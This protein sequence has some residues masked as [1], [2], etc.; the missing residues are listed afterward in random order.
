[1]KKFGITVLIFGLALIFSIS[2]GAWAAY[3]PFDAQPK[4]SC[5]L[6]IIP[7]SHFN[8]QYTASASDYKVGHIHDPQV[9][10]FTVFGP[11]LSYIEVYL[12][13]IDDAGDS[14]K[15]AEAFEIQERNSTGGWQD[16][17]NTWELLTL[18]KISGVH[19]DTDWIE[20]WWELDELGAANAGRNLRYNIQFRVVAD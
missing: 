3:A 5:P 15:A 19:Y 10:W 16:F 20:Y 13:N 7:H 4:L 18:N 11:G 8:R 14:Q 6:G 2:T 9:G 1:M 17:S 12:K